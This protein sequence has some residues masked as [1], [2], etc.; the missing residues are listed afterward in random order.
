VSADVMDPKVGQFLYD[1]SFSLCSI[2]FVSV[3]HL[4][5]NNSGVIFFE[6]DG[7]F[8]HSTWIHSYL[9]EIVSTGSIYLLCGILANIIPVESWEPLSSLAS[10]TF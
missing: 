4:D 7:C 3:F 6:M 2:I 10:G 8:H 5:K 9:L 1:L